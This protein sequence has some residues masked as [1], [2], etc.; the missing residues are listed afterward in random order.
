[1]LLVKLKN[2]KTSL[3]EGSF[4]KSGSHPSLKGEE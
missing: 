2:K 3:M 4:L 1:M